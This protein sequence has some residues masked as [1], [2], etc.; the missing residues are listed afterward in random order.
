MNT[1]STSG[2]RRCGP[3]CFTPRTTSR[4]SHQPSDAAGTANAVTAACPV[5]ARPRAPWLHGKTVKIEPGVPVA[6]PK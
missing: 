1:P 4:C 3:E 2:K 6:S 5:P